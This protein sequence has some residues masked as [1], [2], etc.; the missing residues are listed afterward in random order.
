MLCTL[1]FLFGLTWQDMPEGQMAQWLHIVIYHDN[2]IME[3]NSLEWREIIPQDKSSQVKSS[4][5]SFVP[6]GA[7]GCE[8]VV[9]QHKMMKYDNKR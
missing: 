6:R 1:D 3:E 7:S 4:R 8:A 5:T 2:K 9:T